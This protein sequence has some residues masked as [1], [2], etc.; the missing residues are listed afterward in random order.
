MKSSTCL[1][2]MTAKQRQSYCETIKG[3]FNPDT[4]QKEDCQ[5]DTHTPT[6]HTHTPSQKM[7]GGVIFGCQGNVGNHLVITDAMTVINTNLKS[8]QESKNTQAHAKMVDETR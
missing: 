2:I 1:Q 5:P 6:T 4:K 8:Q 7:T 3:T